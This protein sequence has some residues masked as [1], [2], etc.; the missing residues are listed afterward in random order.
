[1]RTDARSWSIIPI[2]LALFVC[3]GSPA[4]GESFSYNPNP[5]YK[6]VQLSPPIQT[7]AMAGPR[8]G[9]GPR[10]NRDSAPSLD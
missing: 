9:R 10:F 1:M 6:T 5:A 7:P 3:S 4:R 2:M 8:G